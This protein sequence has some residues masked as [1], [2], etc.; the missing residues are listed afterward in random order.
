MNKIFCF[1]NLHNWYYGNFQTGKYSD[2]TGDPIGIRGRVCLTCDKK[3][4]LEKGKYITVESF[5][6]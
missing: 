1:F 5:K 3:Q 6:Q 4:K 2:F